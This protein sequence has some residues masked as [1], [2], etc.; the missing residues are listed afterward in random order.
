MNTIQT[1][2]PLFLIKGSLILLAAWGI[3]LLRPS[4]S[5]S[6]RAAVWAAAFSALLLLPV[7]GFLPAYWTTDL[8]QTWF[9]TD[10]V[11]AGLSRVVPLGQ[12]SATAATAAGPAEITQ[13]SPVSTAD[14]LV[15]FWFAGMLLLG[16]R[17]FLSFLRLRRS[18]AGSVPC[19]D[20][21]LLRLVRRYSEGTAE[22]ALRLSPEL[23]SPVT[24]GWRKPILLLPC[25]A[26]RWPEPE[27]RAALL[28]EIA[29]IRRDDWPVRCLAELAV[30]L[31]WYNP[32]AW[33]A[34]RKLQ[35]AQ[36]TACDDVV[37]EACNDADGYARQLVHLAKRLMAPVPAGSLGMANRSTLRKRVESILA[38]GRS[39]KPLSGSG[40]LLAIGLFAVFSLSPAIVGL[41]EE[42]LITKEE[43]AAISPLVTIESKVVVLPREDVPKLLPKAEGKTA[44][45]VLKPE[46]FELLLRALNKHPDVD[47]LSAPRVVTK[48]GQSARVQIGNEVVVDP[49]IPN[50]TTFVGIHLELQPKLGEETVDLASVLEVVEPEGG[51]SEALE[52]RED[53]EVPKSLLALKRTRIQTRMALQPGD[54]L[55]ALQHEDYQEENSL[56]FLITVDTVPVERTE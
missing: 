49:K 20:A 27:L 54:T 31:H 11:E 38:E 14:L 24:W 2:L 8:P 17:L 29:H 30:C 51:L 42:E 47:L 32:L 33:F 34:R 43:D 48:S 18:L 5:A 50:E 46:K 23:G 6:W 22:P 26:S 55:V 44:I 13:A 21:L 37:V 41:A 39:R 40:R 36:E 28:H 16:L 19:T 52:A 10:R 1:L 9:A 25:E 7:L 53:S 15:S 35:L 4:A 12:A 45:D 56:L 3:S